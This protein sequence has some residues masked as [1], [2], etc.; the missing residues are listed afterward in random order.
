[1]SH[2]TMNNFYSLPYEISDYLGK[3]FLNTAG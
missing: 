1:M 2:F 3:H